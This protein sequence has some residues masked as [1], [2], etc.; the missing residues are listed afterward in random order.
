MFNKKGVLKN[1]AK[2]TGKR[3]CRSLFFNKNL[4]YR[5][6]RAAVFLGLGLIVKKF[7]SVALIF[8]DS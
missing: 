7:D 2:V 3:L 5:T 8:L 6:V 1:F 4:F